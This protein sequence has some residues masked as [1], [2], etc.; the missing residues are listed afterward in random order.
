MGRGRRG[1]DQLSLKI[2]DNSLDD[3]AEQILSRRSEWSEFLDHERANEQY[4]RDTSQ[5]AVCDFERSFFLFCEGDIPGGPGGL[6]GWSLFR[7]PL[8]DDFQYPIPDFD[9]MNG[10]KE[11]ATHLVILSRMQRRTTELYLCVCLR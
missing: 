10:G 2:L 5:R 6:E 9:G 4:F 7:F 1:R 8:F 11:T 3:R